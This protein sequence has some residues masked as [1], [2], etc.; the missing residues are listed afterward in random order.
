MFARFSHGDS[1]QDIANRIGRGRLSVVTRL[2]LILGIRSDMSPLTVRSLAESSGHLMHQAT[3]MGVGSNRRRAPNPL[4]PVA[5]DLLLGGRLA[6]TE[7][8]SISASQWARIP[9]PSFLRFDSPP[10][11]TPER[12]RPTTAVAVNEARSLNMEDIRRAG[13]EIDRNMVVQP[14]P[15]PVDAVLNGS[16]F[17]TTTMPMEVGS[18]DRFRIHEDPAPRMYRPTALQR[19]AQASVPPV[20]TPV[21]PAAPVRQPFS[22]HQQ[23][24]LIATL[25]ELRG[26]GSQAALDAV[27]RAIATQNPGFDIEAFKTSCRELAPA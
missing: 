7:T 12:I 18:I 26:Q 11:S 14:S 21:A 23:Q 2:Q 10:S 22:K 4:S 9:I 19:T 8:G 13:A 20:P 15:V 3:F 1:P 24:A 6:G 5:Q 17:T 25:R 16:L 27:A